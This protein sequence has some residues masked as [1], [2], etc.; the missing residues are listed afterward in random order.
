MLK[1][2]AGPERW[3]FWYPRITLFKNKR[4][5]ISR[6]L[7]NHCKK[8]KSKM[9]AKP[10]TW[11]RDSAAVPAVPPQFRR[12]AVGWPDTNKNLRLEDNPAPPILC[13]TSHKT[14]LQLMLLYAAVSV[15]LCTQLVSILWRIVM[16]FLYVSFIHDRLQINARREKKNI[17]I[18]IYI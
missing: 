18:Y 10:N 8:L 6:T 1:C 16:L 15:D 4:Y 13:Y 2:H 12:L 9:F 11:L 14:I 3:Q 5:S 17:Y 7:N